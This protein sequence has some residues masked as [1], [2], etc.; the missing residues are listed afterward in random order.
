MTQLATRRGDSGQ[1]R[2]YD[3][4][5][6]MIYLDRFTHPGPTP[7][8]ETDCAVTTSHVTHFHTSDKKQ[9]AK[10]FVSL[11]WG[12][13]N[14]AAPFIRQINQPRVMTWQKPKHRLAYTTW[15]SNFILSDRTL[16]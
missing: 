2:H 12:E 7:C 3:M 9:N 15:E 11:F 4:M 5:T 10:C 16:F 14:R 1:L 6:M 8:A 13:P